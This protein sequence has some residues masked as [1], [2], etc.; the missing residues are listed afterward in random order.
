M[1]YYCYNEPSGERGEYNEVITMSE[2]E[3][4]ED[5]WDH[6]YYLMCL[7]FGKDHV[8]ATYT[9]KECLEDWIAVHWAWES[10]DD[11]I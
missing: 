2:E 1:R 7:K 6:W 11:N 5:Y 9:F 3:I 10:K 4:R 8:D